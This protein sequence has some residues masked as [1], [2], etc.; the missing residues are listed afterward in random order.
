MEAVYSI[1]AEI[2][3]N[4]HC[5]GIQADVS[6]LFCPEVS[7]DLNGAVFSYVHVSGY[8]PGSVSNGQV[9]FGKTQISPIL[10]VVFLYGNAVA[11]A[12]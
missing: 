5:T 2:S 1:Q 10:E 6:G 12:F 11:A 9:C 8:E 3:S 7:T 4:I